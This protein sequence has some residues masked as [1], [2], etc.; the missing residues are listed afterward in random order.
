MDLCKQWKHDPY[1]HLRPR[2]EPDPR[3]DSPFGQRKSQPWA[4]LQLHLQPTGLLP[5][6]VRRSPHH[7][8]DER[9]GKRDWSPG[10]TSFHPESSAQLY[11]P[12]GWCSDSSSSSCCDTG[13]LCK[14]KK[15]KDF[16]CSNLNPERQAVAVGMLDLYGK[17]IIKGSPDKKSECLRYWPILSMSVSSGF[18]SS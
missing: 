3:R 16:C 10:H 13:F 9:L 18:L 4:K 14:E 6:P 2:G 17:R 11:D 5:L 12:G 8:S 15:T 1:G 7:C